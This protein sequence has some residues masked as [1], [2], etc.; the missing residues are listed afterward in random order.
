MGFH[1]HKAVVTAAEEVVRGVE[2]RGG[3]KRMCSVVE[4]AWHERVAEQKRG[5]AAVEKAHEKVDPK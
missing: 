5:L 4:N 1:S 3:K 2:Q